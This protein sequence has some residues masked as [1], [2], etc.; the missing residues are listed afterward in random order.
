MACKSGWQIWLALPKSHEQTAPSFSHHPA[1]SLPNSVEAG[2]HWTVVLGSAFGSSSPVPVFSPCFYVDVRLDAGASLS[3][4]MEYAERACYLIDGTLAANGEPLAEQ[5]MAI[6]KP[7]VP[8][9][10]E[11]QRG[12]R[13]VIL[14]GDSMDG[15]RHLFWNFV[16]SDRDLI[17]AAKQR[18]KEGLFPTVP[19]EDEFI[20]LPD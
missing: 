20:P 13:F 3:L 11:A 12:S 15:P 7:G 8:V 18:W 9:H 5:E 16:A 19:G 1:D 10:L 17:E 6:F 14:G 2:V 4:P